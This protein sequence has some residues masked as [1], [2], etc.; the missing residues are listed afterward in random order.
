MI[1][2]SRRRSK[3]DRINGH[4]WCKRGA[5][6]FP[7]LENISSNNLPIKATH[8][9]NSVIFIF[10]K[11]I[12]IISTTKTIKEAIGELT[13]VTVSGVMMVDFIV[14]FHYIRFK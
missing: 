6:V 11:D 7:R 2:E 8:Y 4:L 1:D 14:P 13:N 10:S 12:R 3:G 9:C 5:R